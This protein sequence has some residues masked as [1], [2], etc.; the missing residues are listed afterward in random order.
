[1]AKRKSKDSDILRSLNSMLRPTWKLPKLSDKHER[2]FRDVGDVTFNAK[3]RMCSIRG[4]RT[5][6]GY[7]ERVPCKAVMVDGRVTGP[8]VTDTMGSLFTFKGGTLCLLGR[9]GKKDVLECARE[10]R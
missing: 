7:R 2:A 4:G 10:K 6:S 3:A 1:M 8:I 5:G 9:K